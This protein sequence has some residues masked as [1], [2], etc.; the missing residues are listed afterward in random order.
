MAVGR[1]IVSRDLLEMSADK[2]FKQDPWLSSS[3]KPASTRKKKRRILKQ[4]K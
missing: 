4:N 2:I 1:K 3:S